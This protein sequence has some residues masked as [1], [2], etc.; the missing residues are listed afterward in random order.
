MEKYTI[1]HRGTQIHFEVTEDEM[2]DILAEFAEDFHNTGEPNPEEIAVELIENN[3]KAR[4]LTN[5]P[6]L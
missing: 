6:K 4:Y 3:G 2:L 1:Y 5:P